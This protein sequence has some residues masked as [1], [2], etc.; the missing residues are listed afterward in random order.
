MVVCGCFGG[1][2][3]GM[4]N[5]ESR[6]WF[7]GRNI[8]KDYKSEM[9]ELFSHVKSTKNQEDKTLSTQKEQIFISLQTLR[10]LERKYPLKLI[11]NILENARKE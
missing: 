9:Q 2:Y 7:M 8:T 4:G 10:V 5:N 6:E 3:N 11:L 1:I